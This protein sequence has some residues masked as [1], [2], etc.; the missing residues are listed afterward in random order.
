MTLTLFH[1]MKSCFFLSPASN[2]EMQGDIKKEY[3]SQLD[4]YACNP[5]K[6]KPLT[7][8]SVFKL[9]SDVSSDFT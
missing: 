3:E 2:Q 8:G 7:Q 4:D 6:K 9:K 1:S 5:R